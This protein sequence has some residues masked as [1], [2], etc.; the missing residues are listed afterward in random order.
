MLVFKELEDC[1]KGV[2]ML[3]SCKVTHFDLLWRSGV[4][5]ASIPW[6]F[7]SSRE[8]R[9]MWCSSG[10]PWRATDSLSVLAHWNK[11]I[12]CYQPNVLLTLQTGA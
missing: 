11:W 3:S 5:A 9:G 8:G 2:K 7:G 12:L 10:A 6:E 1:E 4:W